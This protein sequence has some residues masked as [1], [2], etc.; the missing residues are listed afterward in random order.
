MARARPPHN[1]VPDPAQVSLYP[2][3]SGNEINGVGET[4]LRP[5]SPVYWHED[6]TK[7][8]HGKVQQWFYGHNQD[9]A[10]DEARRDRQVILDSPMP[11]IASVR[12]DQT[13]E[14]WAF[15]VDREGRSGGA[16][17]VGATAMRPEWVFEGEQAPF[18]NIIVLGVAMD[19]DIM[20]SAPEVAAGAEV[21]KR[22]GTAAKAAKDVAAWIRRQGWQ[23]DPLTGPLKGKVLMVPAALACGFGEL[24]KHGSIINRELGS[25][26]RLAA[27]LTDLPMEHG[28]ADLFGADNFCTSCQVCASA[29]PPGAIQAEKRTVRGAVKWYV[30]FDKCLP[31]FNETAGCGICL[32]VCPWSKPGT[33]PRLAARLEA[34]AK[35]NIDLDKGVDA[36]SGQAPGSK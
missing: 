14:Q 10:L 35:T 22:Y 6:A 31:F 12:F 33:A 21:L 32:A 13:P 19:Y 1:F 23:A 9:P 27:V 2:D 34:R 7:I 16:D 17:L 29:C 5:P 15:D 26:L 8:A 30:N 28:T 36:E 3:I 20:Q 11:E 25:C 4:D 24:G 18:P